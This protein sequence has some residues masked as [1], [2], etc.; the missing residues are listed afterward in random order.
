MGMIY[1]AVTGAVYL[2]H[3]SERGLRQAPRTVEMTVIYV[4]V[5]CL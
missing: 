2:V 1:R 5:F 4:P 3:R